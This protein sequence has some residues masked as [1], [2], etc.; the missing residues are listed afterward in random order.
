MNKKMAGVALAA[1]LVSPP[2]WADP[3][4]ITACQTISAPG[5]YVLANNL[6]LLTGPCLIIAAS[7]VTIDLAG[8]NILTSRGAPISAGKNVAGIAVRNGSI[9]AD[10]ETG[11][12]FAGDGSIVEGLRIITS[13]AIGIIANGI[14]RGNT[15]VSDGTPGAVGI[16]ATG[17]VTNNYVS[18]MDGAGISVGAGSTV[19]GNTATSNAIGIQADCPSNL[20]DNTAVGNGKNLVLNG[21]GCHNED[22]VA[23]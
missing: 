8:F 4:V 5:S 7:N 14:V 18:G 23:P 11:V 19:I 10:R 20:T 9:S 12:N 15:V 16:I 13:Q 17:A 21:D 2:A 3:T 1:A 6:R 22:N